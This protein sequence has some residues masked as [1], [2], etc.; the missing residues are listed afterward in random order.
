MIRYHVGYQM[1]KRHACS[2]RDRWHADYFHFP[3][4]FVLV[5]VC[6]TGGHRKGKP[7]GDWWLRVIYGKPGLQDASPR[8]IIL[9]P[10]VMQIMNSHHFMMNYLPDLH[11]NGNRPSIQAHTLHVHSYAA[12]SHRCADDSFVQNY[13]KSLCQRERWWK[14]GK[15][16]REMASPKGNHW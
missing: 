9:Y 3:A 12:H 2:L 15:V 16:W 5:C 1:A 4:P 11:F 8:Y 7:R 6:V 10:S 13:I 14:G